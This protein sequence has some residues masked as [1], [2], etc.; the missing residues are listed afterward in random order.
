MADA[1]GSLAED[2]ARRNNMGVAAR[3][4]AEA[5]FALDVMIR[6]YERLYLSLGTHTGAAVPRME[7]HEA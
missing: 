2:P 4:R 1:I 6:E 7:I 3:R 5:V